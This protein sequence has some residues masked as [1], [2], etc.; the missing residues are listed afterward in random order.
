[1]RQ[2]RSTLTEFMLQRAALL[3]KIDVNHRAVYVAAAA[4]SSHDT[5]GQVGTRRSDNKMQ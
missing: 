5:A 3:H 1:M 2:K 4:G